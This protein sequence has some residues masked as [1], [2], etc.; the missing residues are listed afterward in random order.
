MR[1]IKTLTLSARLL[2]SLG[3]LLLILACGY[4]LVSRA[5]TLPSEIRKIA[6][7]TFENTTF[8]P[9]LDERLTEAVTALI[10]LLFPFT[11]HIAE[12]LWKRL[13]YTE[14]LVK[15]QWPSYDGAVLKAEE[16]NIPVQV[17]G[18]LRGV[19]TVPAE[20]SEEQIKERAFSDTKIA[21]WIQGKQITKIIYVQGRLLN[22]V[23]R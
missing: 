14:S 2:S 6:V 20:S 21:A 9:L 19:L 17:N 13:G 15:E 5:S 22:I 12:E 23:V 16:I 7:P 3:G 10:V 18:K 4:Q 8:E 1:F 11:P